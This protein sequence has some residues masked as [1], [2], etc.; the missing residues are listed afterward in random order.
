MSFS[1]I[2]GQERAKRFLKQVTSRERMPHAYLFTGIKGLGKTRMATELAL[3]LNCASPLEGEGCGSC[4]SCRK[5]MKGNSPDF[6]LIVPEGQNVKIEQIRELNRQ[7]SFAPLAKYRVCVVCQAETMTPE[8]ANAFLKTLEEPPQ[9]NILIL[10]ATEPRDL[11]PTIVSRCQRV[12]FQPVPPQ[13]ILEWIV[14][15]K[16]IDR[17]RAEVVVKISGGS[18]GRALKMCEDVFLD[19]RQEWISKIVNLSLLSRDKCFEMAIGCADQAKK[20]SLDTSEDGE[21]GVLDM[22][23][24]WE[25]W[26]RDLLIFKIQGSADLLINRD[27]TH[28]LKKAAQPFMIS[29]LVKS[30]MMLDKA[31]RNL[32]KN[33][34]TSLVLEHTVLN[35]KKLA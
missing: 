11:L 19:K 32:R 31:A 6:L 23:L 12:S 26:Y 27:F 9:Q 35:L 34:N 4:S 15:K 10:S 21:P 20:M 28:V 5:I 7:T 29:N 2:P 13:D 25:S 17:E 16:D 14:D 8:A 33:R 24:V 1:Q 30:L 18:P 3:S 22:L